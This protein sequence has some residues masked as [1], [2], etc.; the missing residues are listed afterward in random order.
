MTRRGYF[1]R[2]ALSVAID[3]VDFTFGRIPGIGSAGEGAGA[4]VL[5]FL[6]GWPGLF[7]LGELADPTDQLDGFLPT[8]T[9]IAL[10]VGV[11]EGYLFGA[12]KPPANGA[13]AKK[14]RT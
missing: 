5:F 7:Y 4:V 2:L 1:I 14:E 10:S 8:A 9:L 13:L 11:K 3:A 6:W 12:G